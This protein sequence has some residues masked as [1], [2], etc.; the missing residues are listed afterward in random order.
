MILSPHIFSHFYTARADQKLLAVREWSQK[1][2]T[3]PIFVLPSNGNIPIGYVHPKTIAQ[4]H[5]DTLLGDIIQTC[6]ILHAQSIHT[7]ASCYENNDVFLVRNE[8]GICGWC[9][10][11]SLSSDFHPKTLPENWN[12]HLGIFSPWLF[13][14]ATAA[15]ESQKEE[16]SWR[17]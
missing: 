1:L 4:C 5:E 15:K 9:D 17:L 11:T 6:P 8:N 12:E 13:H 14:I 2:G 10:K 3:N 16:R 7:D